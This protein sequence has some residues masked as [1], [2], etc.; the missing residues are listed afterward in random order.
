MATLRRVLYLQALV[1]AALGLSLA[2][3][4]RFVLVT[5]FGQ[6][7][8]LDYL[9]VRLGGIDA[10]ALALLMVLVAHHAEQAWWWTWAFVIM[11][12]GEALATTLHAALALPP[13]AAAW[14]WWLFAVVAWGFVV[15]LLWGLASAGHERAAA[16]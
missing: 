10:F 5:L 14:P 3:L 15:A 11:T 12:A 9:L 4:P 13:G 6:P 16:A 1:W 7:E 8:Y 2:L